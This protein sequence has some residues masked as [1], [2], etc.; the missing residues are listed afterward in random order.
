[1]LLNAN[2]GRFCV[3]LPCHSFGCDCGRLPE[4][5]LKPHLRKSASEGSCPSKILLLFM[6]LYCMIVVQL[7]L[8]DK[9]G[10]YV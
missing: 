6:K 2:W 9:R 5:R 4:K 3:I 7:Y 1:M 8:I 10:F